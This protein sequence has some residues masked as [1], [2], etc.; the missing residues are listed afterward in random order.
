MSS[1]VATIAVVSSSPALASVLAAAMR[2]RS[3]WRVRCFASLREL[4]TYMR[5]APVAVIVS[6]YDLSDGSIADFA[7]MIREGDFVVDAGLAIIAMARAIT[8][9]M[10]RECRASGIDE[11]IVKPMSPAYIEERV[12]A[13]LRA[14]E[15][16]RRG[17]PEVSIA[18]EWHGGNV[19]SF[20]A[21]RAARDGTA[22]HP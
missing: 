22:R 5:I 17:G 16:E 3:G 19:I 4:G 11:L 9:D 21:Q 14:Q 15:P 10:R 7:F 8:P 12:E 2:H 6:D 20:A 13:R 1:P 18:P